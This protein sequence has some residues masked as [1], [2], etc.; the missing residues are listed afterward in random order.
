MPNNDTP[1]NNGEFDLPAE[2]FRSSDQVNSVNLK[3]P[4]INLGFV[5][6]NKEIKYAEIDDLG[7]Y[8][9]DIVKLAEPAVGSGDVYEVYFNDTIAHFIGRR[10]TDGHEPII[11]MSNAWRNG[12]VIGNIYEHSHLLKE[13]ERKDK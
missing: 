13:D 10:V 9:G 2:M 3:I 12:E 1:N 6:Q 8:E 5:E 7:I 11:F 4:R